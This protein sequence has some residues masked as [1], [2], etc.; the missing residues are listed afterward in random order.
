MGYVYF[1]LLSQEPKCFS[2]VNLFISIISSGIAETQI[3]SSS[4]GVS[5]PSDVV[6]IVFPLLQVPSRLWETGQ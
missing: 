1:H 5:S 2:H 6:A 4:S 3:K